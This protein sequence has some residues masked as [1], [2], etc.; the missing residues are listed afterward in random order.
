MERPAACRN[1]HDARGR[2]RQR[3]PAAT[4]RAATSAPPITSGTREPPLP[5]A[6]VGERDGLRA[7]EFPAVDPAGAVV[8]V[9]APAA[10]R[11]E[12]G[13]EC[14]PLVTVACVVGAVTGG[15][16]TVDPAGAAGA[17]PLGALLGLDGV[18][19]PGVDAGE[20]AAGLAGEDCDAAGQIAA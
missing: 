10:G 8:L 20:V 16:V 5:A 1:P 6:A 17:D 11:D 3:H 12:D 4:A 15:V 18:P 13:L 2:R 19:E 7:W 14:P 9:D